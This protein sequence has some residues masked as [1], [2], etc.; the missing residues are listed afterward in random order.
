MLSQSSAGLHRRIEAA[1]RD[2]GY[3]PEEPVV[4]GVLAPDIGELV[5]SR[6]SAATR[7]LLSLD[8]VV[9]TASLSKQVTAACL[10]LL[11]QRGA[12]NLDSALIEWIPEL[13]KWAGSVRVRHLVHHTAALPIDTKVDASGTGHGDEDR[14]TDGVIASLASVPALTYQPGTRFAYSNAG[15]VCL[16]VLVQRA[17][18]ERLPDFA[19][20]HLFE[21]IGMS[22]SCFWSGPEPAPPGAAPLTPARPAPLSLGDGGLW[23]TARDL[24]RWSR[25]LNDDELGIS[26]VLQ[27][28]GRLDDGTPIDYAWGLGVR[29]RADH[30]V[31]RHGGA[32]ANLRTLL[33][34]VPGLGL[35]LLTIATA[36]ETERRGPLNAALLDHLIG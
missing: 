17:A 36:D 21:A 8:T 27:T 10:A 3:G 28:P 11:V 24:L 16:G 33:T 25:C 35:S 20:R 18:G 32:Y 26:D 2:A 15:Y 9:Y 31:Y 22:R 14:M 12:V 6:G 29:A 13:P 5:V 7:E 19:R 4:V 23:S 1:L 30:P 34:R